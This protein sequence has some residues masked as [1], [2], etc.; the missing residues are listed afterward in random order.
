MI[1][2]RIIPF[3]VSLIVCF[4]LF[5]SQ[6]VWIILS[7]RFFT[8]VVWIICFL[9]SCVFENDFLWHS[10]TNHSLHRY[11]IFEVYLSSIHTACHT[12]GIALLLNWFLTS[13][14]DG[15]SSQPEYFL[16]VICFFCLNVLFPSFFNMEV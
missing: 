9:S 14:F 8:K 7:D 12:V 5:P 15:K 2:T 16:C 13:K 11:R 4:Y 3:S 10:H 6:V 1:I